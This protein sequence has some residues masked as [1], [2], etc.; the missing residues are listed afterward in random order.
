[1]PHPEPPQPAATPRRFPWRRLFQYSLRTLLVLTAIVAVWFAWWSHKAR[2]QREAVEAIRAAGGLVAYDF[3]QGN[4]FDKSTKQPRYWPKWLVGAIGVD[5]FTHVG[6]IRLD[7]SN[8]ADADLERL[9]AFRGLLGLS[10]DRTD[11]TDAGVKHLSGLTALQELHL[12]NTK[13]SDAGL[14]HLQGLTALRELYLWNTKVT[15]TGLQHLQGLKALRVLYL[16]DTKVTDASIKHLQGLKT[17]QELFLRNTLVTEAGIARLQ[18]ALPTCHI[19]LPEN[20]NA[21]SVESAREALI[22]LVKQ[23][24]VW[25]LTK[26]LEPLQKHDDTLKEDANGQIMIGG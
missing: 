3:E 23:R 15:D 4:I 12:Q 6:G 22:R 19:T 13:V 11:V 17:L 8:V 7:D 5:Y 20:V 10:L 16:G 1:M 26:T 25:P 21:L 2:Q 14:G 24:N 18:K 9:A